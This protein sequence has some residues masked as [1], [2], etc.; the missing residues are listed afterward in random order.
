MKSML[1]ILTRKL[2]WDVKQQCQRRHEALIRQYKYLLETENEYLLLT[3]KKGWFTEK[4]RVLFAM[5]TFF[6]VVIGPL[7]SSSR[8]VSD[9]GIGST[10]PI[11]YGESVI[12][13]TARNKT[14]NKMYMNYITMADE[15]GFKEWWLAQNRAA[16]ITYQIARDMKGDE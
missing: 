3:L 15:F 14:I 6:Q 1:N 9:V 8:G 7:A 12:F 13:D 4:Y 11:Y 16:D 5:N 2:D 10:T